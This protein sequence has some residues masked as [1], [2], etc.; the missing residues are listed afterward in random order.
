MNFNLGDVDD[1]DVYNLSKAGKKESKQFHL[2]ITV[3]CNVNGVKKFTTK[4]FT[5][6]GK[7]R[8]SNSGSPK[9]DS[10]IQQVILSFFC[11]LKDTVHP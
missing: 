2:E 3:N 11:Y 4:D 5:V 8:E 9:V 1:K 6:Y 7:K 10:G